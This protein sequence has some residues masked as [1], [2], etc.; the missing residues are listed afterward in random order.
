ML[1]KCYV[2]NTPMFFQDYW[3]AEIKPH[4]SDKTSSKVII[5]GENTH[6]ELLE[7]VLNERLPEL[8]GGSCNCEATCVY[9][10]KGPWAD[11]ENRINF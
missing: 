6:K 9:S 3:E 4:I 7:R 2:V 8:Y 1:D 10:D 11:V 5:T